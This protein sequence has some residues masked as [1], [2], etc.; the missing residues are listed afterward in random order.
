VIKIHT[1][2][3]SLRNFEKLQSRATQG[4]IQGVGR[5]HKLTLDWRQ[6]AGK[7]IVDVPEFPFFIP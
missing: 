5:T 1:R 3:S 2:K 6:I 4:S 7:D